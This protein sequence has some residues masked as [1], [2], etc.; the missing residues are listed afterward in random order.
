MDFKT[1]RSSLTR[2]LTPTVAERAARERSFDSCDACDACDLT[3]YDEDEEDPVMEELGIAWGERLNIEESR[4]G[5]GCLVCDPCAH[6][7]EAE[8]ESALLA[9][10]V[11]E[12]GLKGLELFCRH[13]GIELTPQDK[14]FLRHHRIDAKA[15]IK[16]MQYLSSVFEPPHCPLHRFNR[17]G[18]SS[19]TICSYLTRTM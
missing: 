5:C 12:Q 11:N 15:K 4:N 10:F 19:H 8:W 14:K 18:V 1:A 3:H 17:S 6:G 16:H 13:N 2:T 9:F 7:V